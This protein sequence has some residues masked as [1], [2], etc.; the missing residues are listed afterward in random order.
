[1]VGVLKEKVMNRGEKEMKWLYEEG[2]WE[3]WFE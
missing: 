3:V 1:M 2:E